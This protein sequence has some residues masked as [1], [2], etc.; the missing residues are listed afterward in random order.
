[1]KN[2]TALLCIGIFATSAFAQVIDKNTAPE[3]VTGSTWSNSAQSLFKDRTASKEGDLITIMISE[4]SVAS[5]TAT[6]N[7]SKADASNIVQDAIKASL[8]FLDVIRPRQTTANSTT[9]GTGTTTS[10]GNLR[11][12]LTA[13]V[14]FVTAAGNLIIEGSRK[15]VINKDTQLFKLTGLVRRDDILPD[16]SVLSEKLAQA[17]IRLEGKG[18]IADRQ[19]KGLLTQVLDWLF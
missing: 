11:A 12:R 19:R 15:I 9:A 4:Q 7:T 3:A 1:M 13:E 5:F 14:K 18:Q 6:T 10:N 16:N 2:L 17:E 8:S